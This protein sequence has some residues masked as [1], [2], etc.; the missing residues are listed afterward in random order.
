AY[1]IVQ[2]NAM[3]AWEQGKDLRTMLEGDPDVVL[4]SQALDEAFDLDR[5]LRNIGR[6]FQHLEAVE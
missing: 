6:T 4:S 2:R 5:A 3:A 1:R